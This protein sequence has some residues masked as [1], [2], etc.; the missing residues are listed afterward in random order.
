ME[1][2]KQARLLVAVARVEVDGDHARRPA[3]LAPALQ[4][5]GGEGARHAQQAA[6]ADG[7]LEATECGLGGE[8]AG[9]VVAVEVAEGDAEDTLAQN[10]GEGMLDATAEAGDAGGGEAEQLVPAVKARKC[11]AAARQRPNTA[12]AGA[13]MPCGR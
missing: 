3:P 10:V 12:A 6:G 7:V 9:G 1:V 4:H 13:A 8:A 11:K 2:V 5:G